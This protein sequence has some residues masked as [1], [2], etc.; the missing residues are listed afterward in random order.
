MSETDKERCEMACDN[1]DDCPECGE[2]LETVIQEERHVIG[3][4]EEEEHYE[5][6]G[7]TTGV[8][9]CGSCGKIIGGY[10]QHNW[11]WCPDYE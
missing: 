8:Y 3:W 10:G 1:S 2:F 11:G 4:N 7:Q 9:R 5:D 6:G